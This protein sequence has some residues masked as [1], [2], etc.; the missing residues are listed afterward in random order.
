[1]VNSHSNPKTSQ[2][3]KPQFAKGQ[4]L[5]QEIRTSLVYEMCN[6]T[7]DHIFYLLTNGREKIALEPLAETEIENTVQRHPNAISGSVDAEH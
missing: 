5:N 6:V 2:M 3:L 1:M 7:A 4:A